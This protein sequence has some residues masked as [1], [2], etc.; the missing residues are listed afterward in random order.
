MFHPNN[1]KAAQVA[2]RLAILLVCLSTI[3]HSAT[4][5]GQTAES[6]AGIGVVPYHP[7]RHRHNSLLGLNHYL[8]EGRCI[9][10]GGAFNETVQ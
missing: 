7:P 4:V 5:I 1:L 6:V 10:G 3:W 9:A 2:A 8:F